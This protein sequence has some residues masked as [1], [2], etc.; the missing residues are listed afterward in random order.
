MLT[1][2]IQLSLWGVLCILCQIHQKNWLGSE[3]PLFWQCQDFEAIGAVTCLLMVF[4][5]SSFYVVTSSS[6]FLFSS[7]LL[8]LLLDLLLHLHAVVSMSPPVCL[9]TPSVTVARLEKRYFKTQNLQLSVSPSYTLHICCF[10]GLSHRHGRTS[11]CYLP[12]H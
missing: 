9:L 3:L 8:H 6:Y 4:F 10:Q 12:C 11:R 7:L 2:W 5:F 1:S